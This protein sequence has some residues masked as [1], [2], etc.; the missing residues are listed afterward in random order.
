MKARLVVDSANKGKI[1]KLMQSMKVRSARSEH[2]PKRDRIVNDYSPKA[3][4]LNIK[5]FTCSNCA[6]QCDNV[7]YVQELDTNWYS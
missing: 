2:D 4:S 6:P 1:G 7:Q 5:D 3:R